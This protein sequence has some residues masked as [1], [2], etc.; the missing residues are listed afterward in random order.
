MSIVKR[1]PKTGAFISRKADGTFAPAAFKPGLVQN[2]P[3]E[4]PEGPVVL[5]QRQI[6]GP[7][8]FNVLK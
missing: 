6:T 3:S 4:Q 8:G 5:A 7:D 2:N 1:H